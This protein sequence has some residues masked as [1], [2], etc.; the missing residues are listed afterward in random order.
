MKAMPRLLCVLGLVCL[1]LFLSN[2]PISIAEAD[3]CA[4]DPICAD[5]C[6]VMC[7]NANCHPTS[8]GWD[9]TG[10][11]EVPF[12]QCHASCVNPGCCIN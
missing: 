10:P 3:F 12:Y 6:F 1:T 8:W 9:C 11:Y 5:D 7:R 2:A 4:F